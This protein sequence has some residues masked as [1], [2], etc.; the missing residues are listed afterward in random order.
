MVAS[1]CFDAAFNTWRFCVR[2]VDHTF[3]C[4]PGVTTRPL[5]PGYHSR[6][7]QPT[8]LYSDVALATCSTL[9]GMRGWVV[10]AVAAISIGR[11]A[12]D[13]APTQRAM[14][15]GAVDY[16]AIG[17]PLATDLQY[18]PSDE[19]SLVDVLTQ[20]ATVTIPTTAL[21]SGAKLVQ[22][23]LYW[24]G[25]IAD[26]N[27]ATASLLDNQVDFTRPG[28][29]TP[30]ATTADACYC[31]DGGNG[32]YD[33][34]VCRA[35][36]TALLGAGSTA[37]AG[38]YSVDKFAADFTTTSDTRNASFS[39]VIVYT[40]PSLPPRQISLRDGAYTMENSSNVHV[41]AL[42]GLGASSPL[43]GDVTWY[44]LDG[45]PTGSS[46]ERMTA[47]GS[48]GG[49]SL[50][51]SDALNPATDAMN[52]T[53]NTVSPARS[54]A[55]GID[56]DRLSLSSA[57]TAF[58]TVVDV[59]Y[60]AG[61]DKWWYAYDIVAVDVAMAVLRPTSSKTAELQVDADGNA[62]P[63][64]GDTVRYTIRLE[65]TGTAPAVVDVSDAIPAQAASWSLVSTGGGADTS[66]ATRV[67]VT[68]IAIP[69]GGSASV[70]LD[71]VLGEVPDGTLMAN[72]ATFDA[73]P[74]GDAGTVTATVV[75]IRR[76]GDGD[77]VFD[78]SDNCPDVANPAQTDSNVDGVGDACQA[79]CGNGV[80]DF[81]ED[82]DSAGVDADD[83]DAAT[84]VTPACGDGYINSA[85]GEVCD[86]ELLCDPATC[87]FDYTIGGGCGGCETSD[88]G[89]P[90]LI[91]LLGA[92][93]VL[94]RR[95]ASG[96]RRTC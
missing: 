40:A 94:R 21:P 11:A 85:A 91:V 15:T 34:Q 57:L 66:T 52:H 45:D 64:P 76:D 31:A 6:R 63:T 4:T 78:R 28:Q 88:Q 20:P 51:L 49:K 44:V 42:A 1:G 26:S 29:S 95:Q 30:T 81:G 43:R 92:A 84:C 50:V 47:S 86:G 70:V 75:E 69:I 12:A 79:V 53:I 24:G 68:G 55:V 8:A 82:C 46:G 38:N 96:S 62:A 83:C 93:I 72:S 7:P 17:A 65:N 87:T 36:V 39:V 2:T 3:E 32:T 19:N 71:V 27:C 58:D 14:W 5:P 56:I 90:W 74:N 25:S 60:Q 9:E 37:L 33:I 73:G 59:T 80:V 10:L 48:P 77:A 54:D 13:T 16:V 61:G 41:V 23:F 67:A 89:A 18:D 35:E 22:A